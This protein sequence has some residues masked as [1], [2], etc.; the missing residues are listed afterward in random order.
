MTELRAQWYQRNKE[1]VERYHS[2]PAFKFKRLCKDRIIHALNNK[3]LHKSDRTVRYLNCSISFLIKWFDDE[4][5][6][7]NHGE[8]WHIDHVI[9]INTF[10]LNRPIDIFLCFS[11]FNLSPLKGSENMSKHDSV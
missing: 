6:I 10:D 8:Y 9:P 2:D 5:T 1:Y 11:W 4:M 3:G 7:D